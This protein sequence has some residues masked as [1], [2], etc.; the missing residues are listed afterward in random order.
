MSQILTDA[1]RALPDGLARTQLA[2]EVAKLAEEG[3]NA[4]K[5]IEQ[6]RNLLRQDAGN[7][8]ARDA[9]KR[10]YRQTGAYAP[11][12]E[13]LRGELERVPAGET[14]A[15]LTLLREMASL[16][17]EHVKS[18]SS[19]LAALTQITQLV[20][21][22]VDAVRE[23]VRVYDALGRVR[24]LLA[25]QTRLAELEAEPRAKAELLRQVARRWLEQFS[26]AQ[27]AT[28]AYEKVLEAEP[29]DTEA[30]AKLKE[31]YAKRRAFKPLY[32]LLEREAAS[33]EGAARRETWIEMAKLAADRLDRG[34][35]A[36]KLYQRVLDEDPTALA[37]LDALEKQAERDKDFKTVAD[38][39]ERR[40][41]A[42]SDEA[43]KL[44][45]LQ[46][47]GAVYAERLH[48]HA[49]AMKTW[50]RVL[51]LSPG[52]AK[53]LRVLR[54]T[55]LG[56]GDYEGLT[57]LFAQSKDWEGL[58]EVLSSAAERAGDAT[59][60]VEL[61]YRAADV[62]ETQLDQPDRAS[63][64]YE[65]V[66]A[67]RPD[68]ERAARALIPLYETDEKWARLP[69]L[70]EVL[71]SHA[72]SDDAKLAILEKLVEVTG[73]NLQDRAAA[74]RYAQRAFEIEPTRKG[75]VAA[76]EA[77]AQAAQQWQPFVEALEAR[78]AKSDD[79][80]EKRTLKAT[81]AETYATHLGRVDEAVAAYRSLVEAEEG[82]EDAVT[83]LDRILRA[84]DRREDLRW[85]Y[86]LRVSRAG[87]SQKVELLGEWAA[88]EEEALGA[89]DRA[90]ELHRRVLEIVPKH[91]RSLRALARLLQHTGSADEAVQMLERDRDQRE[92][93]ERAAREIEIAR[94]QLSLKRPIESLAAVK[95]ALD[96]T[97]G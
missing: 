43:T 90:A 85:L 13:I 82:D 35:D 29:G 97:P 42:V 76:L 57:A 94:L 36:L 17:R 81:V 50:H 33:L 46:K 18:D 70:Y 87:T 10:L 51:E 25:A 8:Q 9:L 4:T 52:H 68:E 41:A 75:A 1:Q 28:E 79:A 48:D 22:D 12:A 30:L 6:W 2:A 62:Y 56:A 23:L 77:E 24:D 58:A 53:A 39:L 93:S 49:A 21:D 72:D 32:D 86:E 44:G 11:L 83:S 45:V 92:G 63:R 91:G 78:L 16:Y 34:P 60:K 19:L 84:Q 95:R 96:L 54:D 88:L 47:L 89:P 31:L 15:R 55:Y 20:P 26:N 27:N 80:R 37:A 40:V 71:L 3:A 74:Y 7:K 73:K 5:A 59:S 61:S 65:R 67:V 66:L 14:E 64:S 38:A 69:T